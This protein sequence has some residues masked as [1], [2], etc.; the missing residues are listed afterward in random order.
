MA[1]AA[2]KITNMGNFPISVY[3]RAGRQ[4]VPTSHAG[5]AGTVGAGIPFPTAVAGFAGMPFALKGSMYNKV[6]MEGP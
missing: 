1:T 6:S 5:P 4:T 2:G 3:E